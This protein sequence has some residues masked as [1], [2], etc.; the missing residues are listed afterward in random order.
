MFRITKNN[1]ISVYFVKIFEG[2][3][4]LAVAPMYL[5]CVWKKEKANISNDDLDDAIVDVILSGWVK[6]D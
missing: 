2:W 3:Y 1:S 5:I 4:T 6:R